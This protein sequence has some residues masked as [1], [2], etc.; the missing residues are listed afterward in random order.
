MLNGLKFFTCALWGNLEFTIFYIYVC[1]RC[2][3]P[4]VVDHLYLH[5]VCV[6]LLCDLCFNSR[7]DCTDLDVCFVPWW[8]MPSVRAS[9]MHIL[10]LP[11]LN[12]SYHTHVHRIVHSHQKWPWI[13]GA[14]FLLRQ[15][16]LCLFIIRAAGFTRRKPC[17]WLHV[18]KTILRE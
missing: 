18:K 10:N 2:H 9:N 17:F 13:I 7:G 12:Y 5:N 15:L 4:A 3:V 1:H 8:S 14:L 16:V 11:D 6:G